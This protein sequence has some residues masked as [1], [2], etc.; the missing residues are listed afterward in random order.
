[1]A[2]MDFDSSHTAQALDADSRHRPEAERFGRG[3]VFGTAASLAVWL[4]L[5]VLVVR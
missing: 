5:I 1:M 4:G 2:V 3:L